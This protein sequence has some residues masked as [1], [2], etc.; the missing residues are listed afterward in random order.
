MKKVA[1]MGLAGALAVASTFAAAAKPED[2]IEYRQGVFQAIK[3]HFGS[4]G[5]VVKGQMDYDAEDFARRAEIVSQLSHLPW[6]GFVED[7]Y[8]G[9]TA[10]LPAIAENWDKFEGGSKML[11]EKTAALAEAAKTGDLDQIRPAFGEVG[12][13]CKGCH[14]NFKD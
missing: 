6:E 8:T 4:M 1:A 3:W 10:A 11:M 13:T 5:A 2:A 14:D 9:D 12:K 7:S